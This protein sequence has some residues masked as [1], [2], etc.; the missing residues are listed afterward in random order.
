MT[1]P[2]SSSDIDQAIELLKSLGMSGYE[3]KA[4]LTLFGSS[5]PLNGYEVAKLSGVPRSTIYE[6]LSKLVTVG[7]AIS[8]RH[9]QNRGTA[10]GRYVAVP[11]D[12]LISR[13]RRSVI[14][15][16][17]DLNSVLPRFAS[18]KDNFVVQ[19]LT[20]RSDVVQRIHDVME[21]ATKYLHLSF[22]PEES[23]DILPTLWRQH[24]RGIETTSLYFGVPE[25]FPGLAVAHQYSSPEKVHDNLGC[26]LFAVVADHREA[27]IGAAE[28]DFIWGMW[29]D[30]PVVAMVASEYV[31]HDIAIQ[32]MAGELAR[33]EQNEFC[34][35]P[36]FAYLLNSNRVSLDGVMTHLRPG[37]P[38]S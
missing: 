27:V 31:R 36:R 29:S 19:N 37:T 5:E 32:L 1:E 18:K 3:A 10:A 4:Y 7:A 25:G 14:R 22:W 34:N 13:Y 38:R 20:G 28:G 17:D 23:L 2:R 35:D 11:A 8:V 24:D 6:T 12:T 30:D 21:G 33:L 9:R 26:R 16:L 15:R